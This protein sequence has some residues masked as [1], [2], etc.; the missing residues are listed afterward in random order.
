[1]KHILL[2][3]SVEENEQVVFQLFTPGVYASI[4]ACMIT[5]RE[6]VH[7]SPLKSG[8]SCLDKRID[9][10]AVT[11]ITFNNRTAVLMTLKGIAHP[12]F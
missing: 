5:G 2:I 6:H 8:T 12:V 9:L 11:I 10:L 7:P 4:I 3:Y 1:M